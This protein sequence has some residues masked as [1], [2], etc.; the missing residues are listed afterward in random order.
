MLINNLLFASAETL[1]MLFLKVSQREETVAKT[2]SVSYF[3]VS[4]A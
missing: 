2:K 4:L 1:G 3:A